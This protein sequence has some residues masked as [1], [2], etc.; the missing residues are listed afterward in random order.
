MEGGHVKW[1]GYGRFIWG[2]N[3][4][5]NDKEDLALQDPEEETSSANVWRQEQVWRAA[6]MGERASEH[7]AGAGG[8]GQLEEMERLSRAGLGGLMEGRAVVRNLSFI[9][10]TVGGIE[11]F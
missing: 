4:E 5:P 1:A 9:L 7:E 8:G 3:F 10:T 6:G 11:G 2:G